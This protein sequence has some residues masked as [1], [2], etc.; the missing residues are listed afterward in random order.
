M[1]AQLL[2]PNWN[3]FPPTARRVATIDDLLATEDK[4]E[5][6]DGEIV[7]IMPSGLPHGVASNRIG[8]S[9]DQYCY[10][11]KHGRAA[12]DGVGFRVPLL[13]SGRESFS[14]D[15]FFYSG[16]LPAKRLKLIDGCPDFAVEV[17]SD[18]DYGPAAE[19]KLA[20]KRVDYFLAGTKVVWDVD[21]ETETITSYRASDP[22]Q[23]IVYRRGDIADAEP[24]VPGWRIAVDDVFRD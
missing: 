6:I 13:P 23:P 2:T 10:Q 4:A 5:L 12:G 7:I 3:L 1:N 22:D 21:T 16:S 14:P 15:A 8:S 18:N 24:A 9:L 19:K 17:R 11:T 20:E